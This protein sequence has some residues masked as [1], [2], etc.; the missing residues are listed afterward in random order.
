MKYQNIRYFKTRTWILTIAILY[1]GISISIFNT[2]I[3]VNAQT[4]QDTN[5]IAFEENQTNKVGTKIP[6]S[7]IITFK[8]NITSDSA[9]ESEIKDLSNTLEDQ[10]IGITS[11]LPSIGVV[12]INTSS[13]DPTGAL[14]SINELQDN[15]NILAIEQEEYVELHSENIPTGIDRIDAESS[16]QNNNS[17]AGVNATI[18]VIDTGI[19][20][21]HP[22][23]NV[24]QDITFVPNTSNGNDRQGH[25]TH[26]AGTAAAKDDSLGVV[27]VA[28]GAKLIAVKVFD[29]RTAPRGQILAGINWVA[30]NA[31]KIDV[32]NL[33]FGGTPSIAEDVAVKRAIQNGVTMV[34]A[35]GN[36]NRDASGESPARVQEAITVSAI[37]DTDGKCGGNGPLV[38]GGPSHGQSDDSFAIFSNYGE[39]VDLA[40]P[41]VRINSTQ[42]GGGYDHRYDGTSMAAPHVTGAAALYKSLHPNATPEQ[43]ADG[44]LNLASIPSITVCST[45]ENNGKGYI[46]DRTHDEDNEA[47]N[48]LYTKNLFADYMQMH[49]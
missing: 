8:D 9:I 11:A 2:N 43:V 47:E 36:D 24:I 41:G 30:D 26:V 29:G 15:E 1:I 38:R 42:P 32:A 18:A 20:L 28:P 44:I 23:L 3:F 19:D 4:N 48:F 31:D 14:E 6:N 27:G 22:D 45:S 7:W 39:V 34:V 49:R 21:D 5:N 17:T 16:L 33:S 13:T 35:A 46:L 37:A 10:G 12:V 25:G 40:A